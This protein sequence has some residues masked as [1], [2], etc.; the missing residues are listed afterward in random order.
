M[1]SHWWWA[2]SD[3]VL[4]WKYL[5]FV[6]LLERLFCWM[7]DLGWAVI[8]SRH[9][10]RLVQGL[11]GCTVVLGKSAVG[12]IVISLLLTAIELVSL[13]LCS[14]FSLQWG[15][16]RFVFAFPG[17][18]SLGFLNLWMAGFLSELSSEKFSDKL[19]YYCW[20]SLLSSPS[21]TQTMCVAF[22]SPHLYPIS[23]FFNISPLYWMS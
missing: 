13:S 4:L 7:Y 16:V 6:L 5:H 3:F 23:S 2:L 11:L 15:E 10:E 20:P 1:E 12:L 8:F 19:S 17:W 9:L 18:D 21:S 22:Y 14:A